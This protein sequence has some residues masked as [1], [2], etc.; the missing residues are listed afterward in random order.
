[1]QTKQQKENTKK[2]KE[3][4]NL[5]FPGEKWI[6]VEN[7]IYLSPH[8]AIGRN[9]GY[10]DEL[11]CAQILRDLGSTVYL[12]PESRRIEGKKFDAIVDGEMYEF[13]NVSGKSSTL[14]T[15]N[16]FKFIFLVINNGIKFLSNQTA[17]FWG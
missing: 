4:A 16:I 9:S 6:T 11:R 15:R 1:M 10:E 13:K 5:L 2:A 7:G 8:R 14:V 17:A 3:T 12:A